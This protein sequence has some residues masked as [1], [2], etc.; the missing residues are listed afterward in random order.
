[1]KNGLGDWSHSSASS[2]TKMVTVRRAKGFAK[3]RSVFRF[4]VRRHVVVRVLA[5][6]GQVLLNKSK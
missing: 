3:K 4:C 2:A 6:F 5:I 1:M